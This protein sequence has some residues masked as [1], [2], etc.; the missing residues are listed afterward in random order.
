[1]KRCKTRKYRF[2]RADDRLE[3]ASIPTFVSPIDI[4]IK[5]IRHSE[6]FILSEGLWFWLDREAERNGFNPMVKCPEPT[7]SR[8]AGAFVLSQIRPLSTG[9]QG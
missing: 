1:M 7:D 4:A 5:S 8:V 9:V 3:E 6:V 2:L